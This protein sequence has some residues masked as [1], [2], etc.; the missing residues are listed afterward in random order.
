[1]STLEDNINQRGA[2]PKLISDSAQVIIGHKVQDILRTLCISSWQSKPYQQHQNA[3]E[4]C[5]QTIKKSATNRLLNRTGAPSNTWLLC[6]R[7]IGS[8]LNHSYNETIKVIP[9]NHCTGV[10]VDIS[11]FLRFHFWQKVYNKAVNCHFPSYSVWEIVHI[12]DISAHCGHALTYRILNP[13]AK[14]I[15]NQSLVR[16]ADINHWFVLLIRMI[17][18]CVLSCLV[19]RIVM[20]NTL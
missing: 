9:F 18:I 7:Y 15:I 10:T 17:Q 6:L 13:R 20:S 2:S 16:P 3:A 14:K 11:A 12:V 4:R 5:Y 19:G 8:L 1:M